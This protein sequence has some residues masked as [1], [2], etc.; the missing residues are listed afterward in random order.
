MEQGRTAADQRFQKAEANNG[1]TTGRETPATKQPSAQTQVQVPG[2]IHPGAL[3]R[4]I[5]HD[6]QYTPINDPVEYQRI[7]AVLDEFL[8]RMAKEAIQ[9]SIILVDDSRGG[10]SI[11]GARQLQ[12]NDYE[13][14]AMRIPILNRLK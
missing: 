13:Y 10:H 12:V 2:L 1:T 3:Q 4:T 5:H 6:Y 7:H 9:R 14:V 8:Q 11:V